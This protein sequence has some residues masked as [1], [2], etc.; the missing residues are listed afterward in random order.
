MSIELFSLAWK[1]NFQG[2]PLKKLVLLSLADQANDRDGYCWPTYETIAR[3]CGMNR[4]TVINAVAELERDG[5][6]R[7][8]SRFRVG[9]LH[10]SNAFWVNL[11]AMQAAVALAEINGDP[12]SPQTSPVVNDI[13]HEKGTDLPPPPLVVNDIHHNGDPRS[14]SIVNV[15]HHDGDPRSPIT[16]IEPSS[17]PKGEPPASAAPTMTLE[18]PSD[19]A[20]AAKN[21]LTPI[22]D[23]IGFDD[24]LSAREQASLNPAT[25]LAWAYWV[26]LKRAE[27]NSRIQNPV[28]LVRAQWRSGKPP[29]TDLLALARGWL[30]MGDDQRSRLLGRL[31]W[32][33]D[34]AAFD[35]S[36]PLEDEF[37]Q[38]PLST[39]SAIYSATGGE[40]GPPSLSPPTATNLPPAR[41]LIVQAPRRQAVST[42]QRTLWDD[43]LR[44]LEMQMTRSMFASWLSGSTATETDLGLTIQVRNDYAVD[45]LT[46]RLHPLIQRTV[47]QLAGHRIPVH[48]VASSEMAA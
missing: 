9:G 26:Q 28:G 16:S 35:P 15:D 32:A 17:E 29:R 19:A 10:A 27:R 43:A 45:W 23:W 18:T 25:L 42:R 24:A 46:N 31:E 37:P 22:L 13:H 12:D 1:I 41:A 47:D 44:E 21:P 14:P 20:D 38:I 39:A 33:T 7:R 2:K 8:E 36:D 11:K 4:R 6:I 34:F 5:F 40:L 3:R 48:Y 30:A